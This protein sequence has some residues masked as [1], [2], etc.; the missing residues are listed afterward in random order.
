MWLEDFSKRVEQLRSV[1]PRVWFGGLFFP[2]A[3]MTATRQVIAQK[4]SWSMD[5]LEMVV[6]VGDSQKDDAF[7]FTGTVLQG[8]AWDNNQLVVTEELSFD[9]PAVGIRYV[10]KKDFQKPPNMIPVPVYLNSTRTVI[11]MQVSL[12]H[13][14][15][16]CHETFLQRGIALLLW[17]KG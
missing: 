10:H 4:N 12:P 17:F 6:D 7:V 5:E 16:E 9:M 14:A 11:V 8:A 1:P 3:Y 13:V 15:S 2:E